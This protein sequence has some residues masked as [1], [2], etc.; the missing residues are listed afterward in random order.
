MNLAFVPNKEKDDVNVFIDSVTCEP[1]AGHQ[2]KL[3]RS[4]WKQSTGRSATVYK[5]R[6]LMQS[7]PDCD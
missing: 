3:D 2:Y 1:M 6:R 4:A 7:R 5:V